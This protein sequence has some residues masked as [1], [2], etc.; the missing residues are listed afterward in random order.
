M[1]ILFTSEYNSLNTYVR[2]IVDELKGF[3]EVEIV[4]FPENFWISTIDFD[5]VHIQ[6]PEELFYWRSVTTEDVEKL[7]QRIIF[8]KNKGT[9]IVAT[10]HNKIPHRK[11]T[12]DS[13]LY[14]A[15]YENADAIIHLGKY[16]TSLYPSRNNVIIEHPNYNRHI[17]ILKK[18][19]DKVRFV[20]FGGIRNEDEESQLI[21]AFLTA[22][23][24]NSELIISNSLMGKR[25]HFRKI[26]IFSQLKQI[27]QIKRLQQ[28]NIQL[29]SGILPQNKVDELLNN[30][31]VI[32]SPR[33]DNL[34]SGVIFLGFS[35]GK[36]VVGAAIG[37]MKEYLV[38]NKNPMF[39]PHD[40]N[41][42]SE[43]LKESLENEHLGKKNKVYSDMHLEPKSIAEKH[44][45]LYKS[46]IKLSSL[47]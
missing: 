21:R 6:W 19:T 32:I 22:K 14:Q 29:I 35:Y 46:L 33:Q 11:G 38:I 43:A 41:S 30:A 44:L 18:K 31:D 20:S 9:K 47:V 2:D 10:L 25:Q 39:I 4:T 23:I 1:K 15:V 13:G 12:N 34:N 37:N 24:P 26:E 45:N 16:S 7:N 8:L 40:I 28:K 5:I 3:F 27:W 42:F 17:K 36:P